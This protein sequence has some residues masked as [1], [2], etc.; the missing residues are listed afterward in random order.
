MAGTLKIGLWLSGG[1]CLTAMIGIVCSGGFGPCGPANLGPFL[2]ALAGLLCRCL[3]V[4]MMIIGVLH[5]AVR[6]LRS[7]S[8]AAIS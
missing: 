1:G 5:A 3:G 2:I 4:P 8:S 6:K 7:S